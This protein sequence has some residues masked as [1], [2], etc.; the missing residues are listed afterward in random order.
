MS[1]W[2]QLF[3]PLC[4]RA[5]VCACMCVWVSECVWIFASAFFLSPV[6]V[7][8]DCCLYFC[9]SLALTPVPSLCCILLLSLFSVSCCCCSL[10]FCHCFAYRLLHTA[11]FGLVRS[12][13]THSLMHIVAVVDL[14]IVLNYVRIFPWINKITFL[15]YLKCYM[16][17]QT[18]TCT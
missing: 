2:L 10:W 7:N 9:E 5:C 15:T 4:V 11:I 18:W 13:R 17:K 3:S 1:Q 6:R 16:K 8:Y 14:F 12:G